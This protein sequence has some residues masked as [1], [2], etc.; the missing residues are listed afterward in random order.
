MECD[1]RRCNMT[2]ETR[3]WREFVKR[4]VNAKTLCQANDQKETVN[5]ENGDGKAAKER[6]E[7]VRKK[8]SP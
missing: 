8:N 4:K 1:Q 6:Q 7:R 3:K 2:Y 5:K